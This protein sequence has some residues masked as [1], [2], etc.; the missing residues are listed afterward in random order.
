MARNPAR[1][2]RAAMKTGAARRAGRDV[3]PSVV[4]LFLLGTLGMEAPV[5]WPGDL[6]HLPPGRRRQG[7]EDREARTRGVQGTGQ[8]GE[9]GEEKRVRVMGKGRGKGRRDRSVN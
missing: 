6:R 9:E 8:A 1:G 4:W 7:T 2:R 3:R 5:G